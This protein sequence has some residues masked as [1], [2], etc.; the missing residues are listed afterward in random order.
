MYNLYETD[1]LRKFTF[2]SLHAASVGCKQANFCKM[3][4]KIELQEEK[5]ENYVSTLK[6]DGNTE[7][8][9]IFKSWALFERCCWSL[10]AGNIG[11]PS[12]I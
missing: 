4:C 11:C 2:T 7:T 8:S 10:K 3:Q 1:N 12:T 5:Q 9:T 6:T